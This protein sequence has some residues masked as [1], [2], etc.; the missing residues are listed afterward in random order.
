MLKNEEPITYR[1][2]TE[3]MVKI[4]DIHYEKSD[5]ENIADESN[6]LYSTQQKLMLLLLKEF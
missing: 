1:E 5:L 2:I 4:K 6:D 3:R